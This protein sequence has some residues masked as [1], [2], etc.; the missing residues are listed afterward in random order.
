MK[1]QEFKEK[2]KLNLDKASAVIEELE[3]K[4]NE[5][6]IDANNEYEEQLQ[7]LKKKK[8]FLQSKY[9]QLSEITEDKWNETKED[10]IGAMQDLKSKIK[11][12]LE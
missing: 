12:I 2:A 1:K 8:A 9:R 7:N 11:N 3:M 10:F 5:I 4:M 6:N